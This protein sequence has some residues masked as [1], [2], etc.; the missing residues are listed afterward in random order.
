MH[1]KHVPRLAFYSHDTMGLGHIR[2]NLL[3]TDAV[4]KA[5]PTAEVLLI[6]GVRESGNFYLPKGADIIT[7]PSYFKNPEGDYLPRSLGGSVRRLAALRASTICAALEAF[8][9]DIVIID[10][11]P[12]GAMSE[13]RDVLPLLARK[14]IQVV[15]GLRD[16]ID[17]PEVAE[18]QWHKLNNVATLRDYFSAVWIY[19]DPHFYDLIRAYDFGEAIRDKTLFLGYLD[20]RQRPRKRLSAEEIVPG[21][22]RPYS[23]CVVGGGQDGFQLASDFARA[24]FP[25]GCMGVLVTGS[26]MPVAEQEALKQIAGGRNDLLIVGFVAEPLE[27][28]RQARSVVAMGG[29][30]TTTEILSFH[31][32]AL[33]VPRVSP[34]LEQWIRASRL[35][36]RGLVTCIA[37]QDMCV[38]RLNTWL[39]QSTLPPDPREQLNFNGLEGFVDNIKRLFEKRGVRLKTSQKEWVE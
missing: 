6:N 37:P 27:L 39:R 29:Y 2:R 12:N 33:I 28:L 36:A 16:I 31:K 21:I 7:L 25:Q 8:S 23:L 10:N 22:D 14:Q 26:M 1:G 19:G 38:A 4:L 9:P 5:V 20:A 15:L 32:R 35:A 3:L 13:L 18:R 24:E 11:V 34:R 17:E 30:N